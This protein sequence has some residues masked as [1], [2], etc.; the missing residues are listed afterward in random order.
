MVLILFSRMLKVYEEGVPLQLVHILGIFQ[1]TP[2]ASISESG[3]SNQSLKSWSTFLA[4]SRT[5]LMPPYQNQ[6]S[7]TTFPQQLVRILGIFQDTPDASI[8]ES[9]GFH[10]IPLEAGPH[11]WHFPGHS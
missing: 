3:G 7:P 2:D 9:G 11:S 1:D 10:H 8:S 4:F 5:L 6:V